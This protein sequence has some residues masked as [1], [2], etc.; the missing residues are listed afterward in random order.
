VNSW[1]CVAEAHI[2]YTTLLE[3]SDMAT[4]NCLPTWDIRVFL[5]GSS[6]THH[7]SYISNLEYDFLDV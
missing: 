5:D 2:N 6:K 4:Q 1:R 7:Y 3:V